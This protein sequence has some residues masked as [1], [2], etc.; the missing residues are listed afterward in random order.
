MNIPNIIKYPPKIPHNILN[1]LSRFIQSLLQ[2]STCTEISL[3]TT[4]Q[5]DSPEIMLFVDI[6]NTCV[7]LHIWLITSSRRASDNA[8]FFFGLLS[9]SFATQ[10][11]LPSMRDSFMYWLNR[12][13]GLLM[14]FNMLILRY[15]LLCFQSWIYIPIIRTTNYP[16]ILHQNRSYISPYESEKADKIIT[17]IQIIKNSNKKK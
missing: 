9:Y 10:L 7:Q 5:Y 15:N 2:I 14:S 16:L 8:F 3:L 17:Y 13:V 6:F 4:L 12:K 1:I 11:S